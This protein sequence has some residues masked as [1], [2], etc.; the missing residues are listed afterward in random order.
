MGKKKYGKNL[1]LVVFVL[2]IVLPWAWLL[3]FKNIFNNANHENRTLA[4]KPVF[5]FA[6]Y[7]SFAD[8]YEVYFNDH[9]PFRSELVTLNS[10]I[11]FYIFKKPSRKNVIIGRNGWL[12]YGSKTL[13]DYQHNNLY[14]VEELE[15]IKE[16]VVETKQFLEK[17]GI[18]FVIFIG[19]NKNTIYGD[20]MPS[21]IEKY[22]DVSRAQQMVDYLSKNT[23]VEIIFPVDEL[24]KAREKWPHLSLYLKLDTHWN[25]LGGYFASIPLLYS[26]GIN[27]PEFEEMDYEQ[28]SES[29]FIWNGYDL[30]NFLGMTNILKKDINYHL[31]SEELDAVIYEGDVQHNEKDFDNMIRTHSQYG[32]TRKVFFVRDSFGEAITPYLASSFSEVYSVSRL[33]FNPDQIE[34]EKPDVLIFEVVERN[35]GIDVF[36]YSNWGSTAESE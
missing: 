29:D 31:H 34:Q 9:M 36:N 16:D 32:D 2:V 7:E 19:P 30:A 3:L 8:D 25:Y 17:K 22:G 26:L 13:P 23:D 20:Y 27:Y 6:N 10:I 11:D 4:E 1:I 12:F 18:R 35:A 24:K 15:S 14:T 5:S 28:V 33:A 21:Y